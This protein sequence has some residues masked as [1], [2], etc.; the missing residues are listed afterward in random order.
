MG[1]R[2]R[3]P[4][5]VAL[6]LYSGLAAQQ[7][8]APRAARW[9]IGVSMGTSAFTGATGGSGP[10]G[11][12]LSFTPYRPTMLGLVVAHGGDG[13]RLALSARHG[14]P[15]LAIR[16]LPAT[17]EG[18][19][20]P[21]MMLVAE[22][23]Y[24]LGTFTLVG[25]D[26]LLRLRGGPVLR[27]SLGVTVERWTAPGS[28]VRTIAGGQSGV[29]M[30]VGLT[31]ALSAT[32]EAELGFTPS[33]PFRRQDLPEGFTPRSTWRRSLAAAVYWRF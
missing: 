15:A 4:A 23:A 28:P 25:S 14:E 26:R 18:E 10:T 1:T 24:H 32:I 11:E 27:P 13:L 29:A 12:R 20:T 3:L 31:A 5:I 9:A 19:V 8:A 16:G 17:D 21:G 22:D 33:S 6:T 7:A 2:L 30:E